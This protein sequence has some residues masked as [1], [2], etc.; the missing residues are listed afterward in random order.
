MNRWVQRACLA[1]A[2]GFGLGYSPVAPGTVGTLWGVLVVAVLFPRVSWPIEAAVAVLLVLISV[3]I[4]NVG[5]I[6]L[7]KKDPPQVVADEYMT[8]PLCSIG[9][10]VSEPLWLLVAFVTHRLFDVLKPP[11]ARSAQRLPGGWGIVLDDLF[12]SL[13]SLAANHAIVVSWRALT[14]GL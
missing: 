2:T 8:F 12:S 11:P 4:C 13:Y 14:H 10:P 5:E 3:P 9:L 7:G 1:A 6:K